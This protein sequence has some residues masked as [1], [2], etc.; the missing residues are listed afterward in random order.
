MAYLVSGALFTLPDIIARFKADAAVVTVIS[1]GLGVRLI[2]SDAGGGNPQISR[3]IAARRTI[4]GTDYISDAV[5]D[6]VPYLPG[7]NG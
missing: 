4:D 1:S 3:K 6:F 7:L 2:V 5:Y